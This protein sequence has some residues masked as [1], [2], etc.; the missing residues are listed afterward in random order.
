MIF[1]LLFYS[2]LSYLLPPY[3]LRCVFVHLSATV[4]ILIPARAPLTL[5]F[6]ECHLSCGRDTLDC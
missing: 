2:A 3:G 6:L 4:E 1:P 5:C